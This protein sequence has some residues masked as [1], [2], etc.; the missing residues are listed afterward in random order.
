M[1]LISATN[2]SQY[3]TL[4]ATYKFLDINILS[5]LSI[6]EVVANL[7]VGRMDYDPKERQRISGNKG[8]ARNTAF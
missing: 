1:L 4:F 5:G 8:L 6:N 7:K 2:L 3:H